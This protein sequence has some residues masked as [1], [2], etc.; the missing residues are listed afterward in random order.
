MTSTKIKSAWSHWK[1]V[2]VIQS[3]PIEILLMPPHT[4]PGANHRYSVAK[5]S[6]VLLLN[7]AAT[8]NNVMFNLV[9]YKINSRCSEKEAMSISK[10]SFL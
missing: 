1:F 9:H 5:F 8:V 3:S 7:G 4:Y 6:M 2:F 10:R